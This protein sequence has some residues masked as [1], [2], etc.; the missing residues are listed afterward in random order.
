MLHKINGIGGSSALRGI[1]LLRWRVAAL[2]QLL[3][4]NG[5]HRL[6]WLHTWCA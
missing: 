5:V 2:L 6:D 4:L 3:L 1:C